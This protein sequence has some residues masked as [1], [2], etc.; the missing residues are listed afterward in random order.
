M[1]VGDLV[2]M[3]SF[4]HVMSN[5]FTFTF[6]KPSKTGTYVFLFMGVEEE[7]SSFDPV[8]ILNKL[9]W[10]ENVEKL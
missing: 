8:A 4:S 3:R 10:T 2:N 7:N 9:G 6:K 5:G 1:K